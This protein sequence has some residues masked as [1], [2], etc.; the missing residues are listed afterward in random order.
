[1]DNREMLPPAVE[2]TAEQEQE[3]MQLAAVGMS[4]REIA[5]ALELEPDAARAF[6]LLA[7]I[8]GEKIA[9]LL[10]SGKATGR[11][12]PQI[13]LQEQAAA[14]NIDAIKLLQDLQAE[15]KYNELLA[16][17]DDDEFSP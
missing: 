16:N 9:R 8:P 10:V 6:C 14:G 7:K 1:M 17:I 11:A 15:N 2:L 13:K 5:I 3:V 4:P 12:I